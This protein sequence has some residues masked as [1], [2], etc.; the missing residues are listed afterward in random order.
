MSQF[1]WRACKSIGF[2]AMVSLWV[3]CEA[4]SAPPPTPIPRAPVILATLPAEG[5][6]ILSRMAVDRRTGYVYVTLSMYV[7]VIK[8]TE[9]VANLT[10]AQGWANSIAIDEANDWVYVTYT[11]SDKI[12]IIHD[13]QLITNAIIPDI[14]PM[15]VTI[16]PKSRWAYAVSGYNK[17]FDR[18]KTTV[19]SNI[20]VLNGLKV[21]ANLKIE[22]A[23]F[24]HVAADANGYVY[25]GDHYG[26]IVVF[27]DLKEVAR[28][29]GILIGGIKASIKDITVDPRSGEVYVLDGFDNVRKL[30]D[31]KLIEEKRIPQVKNK[32]YELI[33]IHPIT[34]YIHLLS[35]GTNEVVILKDWNSIARVPVGAEPIRMEID[36]LTGNV[37]VASFR[38]GTV[39]VINGTQVLGTI[40]T[41]RQPVALGINPNNGWVYVFDTLNQTISVLGYPPPNYTPPAPTKT[42]PAPTAPTRAPTP[43]PYP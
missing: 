43:K 37:Y 36:P 6:D 27:K 25:A 31:G 14:D 13:T 26:A 17:R 24:T 20:L 35:K 9:V 16:E 39:T 11:S 22:G 40:K 1:V 18:T 32:T 5:F 23:L 12:S 33:R 38:D 4:S 3:G 28:Y 30:K 2:I 8:D 21:I 19:D 41:G 29:E 10:T 15:A 7:K 42:P 34:G